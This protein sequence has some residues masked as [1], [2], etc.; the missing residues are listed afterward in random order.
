MTH[1][2]IVERVKRWLK[3]HQQNITVPNCS[4]VL[5]EL[6]TLNGSGEIPDVIGWNYWS[7][8]MIEVKTS[9]S[10]FLADKNKRFKRLNNP[11]TGEFKFY[12]CP[13]NVIK[14]E[15][16]PEKY[17]LLYISEDKK[18]FII[19]P[20]ERQGADLMTERSLLLS[21]IRRRNEKKD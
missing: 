17:G 1:K 20:A 13:S 16:L 10:D 18:V 21:F 2:E 19:K 11:G 5:T 7:S 8:V 3:H 9:R 4:F 6:V 14:A 15:E 12:C